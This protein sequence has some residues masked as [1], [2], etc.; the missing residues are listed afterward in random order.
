MITFFSDPDLVGIVGVVPEPTFVHV[1]RLLELVLL[2]E[3]LRYSIAL[4]F[5][6]FRVPHANTSTPTWEEFIAGKP[7]FFNEITVAV[8]RQ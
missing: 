1:R 6:G 2:S 4:D 7:C 8:K 5:V 3:T